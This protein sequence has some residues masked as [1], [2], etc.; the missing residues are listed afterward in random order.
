MAQQQC[1]Q[2]IIVVTSHHISAVTGLFGGFARPLRERNVKCN[3]YILY[4]SHCSF[5]HVGD[6]EANQPLDQQF[7]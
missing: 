6:A 5:N 2:F 4:V 7:C 1:L 3:N